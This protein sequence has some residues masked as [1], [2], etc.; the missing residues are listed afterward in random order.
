MSFSVFFSLVI[1]AVLISASYLLRLNLSLMFYTCWRL[2]YGSCLVHWTK[3]VIYWFVFIR[4]VRWLLMTSSKWE[5]SH[6]LIF[7]NELHKECYKL[8]IESYE[9][10]L[11]R[12]NWT[13][14]YLFRSNWTFFYLFRSNRIF[15]QF[16]F[17]LHNLIFASDINKNYDQLLGDIDSDRD[18]HFGCAKC[19]TITTI[20][21]KTKQTISK[22]EIMRSLVRAHAHTQQQ[23][24]QQLTVTIRLFSG[25]C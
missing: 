14:F 20:A 18:M 6:S 1:V 16:I 7:W 9:F 5:Y 22:S 12:S 10:H 4:F 3:V 11:F 24:L 25:R 17:R 15:F 21:Q 2:N 23:F 19:A 13:F 8:A